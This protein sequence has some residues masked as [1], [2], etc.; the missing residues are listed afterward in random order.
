MS[1]L[2][3]TLLAGASLAAASAA[4][5][6]F[7]QDAPEART[8][9]VESI[10]V[11]A[12]R[13]AESLQDVPI[14]ITALG[15]AELQR[16]ALEE[17]TDLRYTAPNVQIQKNTGL[18]NGAQVY[19]RGVGQ[20]ES[21]LFAE[22]GVGIYVDGVY[23]GK[24]NGSTLDLVDL[25]RVELLRGP[26]GT[27]YGRNTNGGA[28]R[29]ISRRP[30]LSGD[31]T[32]LDLAV[33]TQDRVDVRASYSAAVIENELGVKFDVFSRNQDGDYDLQ[34][35]PGGPVSSI[36]YQPEDEV[37]NVERYGGRA[38]L[39]WTPNAT[40]ELYV[41]GD[42]TWDDS[43][44]FLPTPIQRD[45]NGTPGA[46]PAAQADDLFPEPFGRRA[47]VTS[48][49]PFH[50]YRGGG[51]SATL[52][53][54]TGIGEFKSITAFRG[55][56][57]D[58]SVDLDGP[59]ILD[60][61]QQLEQEQ[62][63]QEFQLVGE[64]GSI[65]YIGGV[66]YFYEDVEQ[67][68]DNLFNQLFAFFLS[69]PYGLN[70]D[71]QTTRSYAVFGEGTWNATDKLSLTLGGRFTS[72]EKEA[73]RALLDPATRTPIWRTS[74]EFEDENFSFRVL[75]EYQFTPSIM[76]YASYSTGYKAGG[77]AGTRPLTPG[78]SRNTYA[79]E[80]LGAYEVGVRS[81]LFNDT[82][83]LNATY[84]YSVYDDLQL[85][86]L[87]GATLQFGVI[88]ADAI[89]EGLEVEYTWRPND[90][91]QLSGNLATADFEYDEG[92]RVDPNVGKPFN[93]LDGKQ[94]PD[95]STR[96]N[97]AFFQPVEW[98]ELSFGGSITYASEFPRNV[99]NSPEIFSDE[100]TTIDLFAALTSPD[101]WRFQIEGKNVTD[102]DFFLAG[103]SAGAADGSFGSRFYA[104]GA[105]WSA[106]LRLEF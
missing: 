38:A 105:I 53:L 52:T 31:R 43:G 55:F 1:R 40:T 92:A 58:T 73:E 7:A 71:Q 41:V 57:Q 22:V 75:G 63:T 78:N 17:I 74:P 11:T 20:D 49:P 86:V 79:P 51:L 103:S 4:A 61:Y 14:A 13:R 67:L 5:P 36:A 62:F 24:Q 9:G 60:L 21:S 94:F 77:F 2:R 90:R 48:I 10:T 15:E 88:N 89:V 54:D 95:L 100:Q 64:V 65:E 47:G 70:D 68:A 84:F 98:G 46:S 82:L 101:G 28:I 59:S 106:S 8:G 87:E 35:T 93:T 85:S 3:T 19:I 42:Y 16:Q 45:V 29:F 102:E 80:E 104:P 96:A 69:T 26:Q 39:L 25:E 18:A 33:G 12:Q 32:M 34:G 27:Y 81:D 56:N 44:T 66:Y 91:F 72:D 37:N 50:E 97:I 99:G 83:R 30:E 6:A 23:L 76:G